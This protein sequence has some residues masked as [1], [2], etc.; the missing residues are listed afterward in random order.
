MTLAHQAKY[1]VYHDNM[2]MHF[3]TQQD[4][5]IYA[6]KQ[7]SAK[8]VKHQIIYEFTPKFVKIK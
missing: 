6:D 1:T 5:Q 8:I 7:K 3:Q 4:A 2:T